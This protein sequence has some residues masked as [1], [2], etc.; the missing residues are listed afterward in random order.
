MKY[1]LIASLLATGSCLTAI[2]QTNVLVNP[3]FENG[4]TNW[5]T[6]AY[7]TGYA[8]IIP[9]AQIPTV[10]PGWLS[11]GN[12]TN[13]Y[14]GSGAAL[15]ESYSY[16]NSNPYGGLYQSVSNN[17]SAVYNVSVQAL[18]AWATDGGSYPNGDGATNQNVLTLK[19][20]YRDA[21]NNLLVGSS[22]TFSIIRDANYHLC[23]TS[24][25]NTVPPSTAFVG[26]VLAINK[27]NVAIL[28]DDA[29][30]VAVPP[31]PTPPA[32]AIATVGGQEVFVTYPAAGGLFTLQTATNVN[33]PW[34]PATNGVPA[35]SYLFTNTGPATFFRLH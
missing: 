20:E 23:S 9:S 3:G 29:S 18:D 31:P 10:F 17:I 26:A 6:F 11:Q 8:H 21:L 7:N 25:T 35:I 27:D 22:Q 32:I 2:A 5:S 13:V 1:L 33:G 28:L 16:Y 15:Y 24:F 4:L 14:A 12:L 19:V 30:L 34:V